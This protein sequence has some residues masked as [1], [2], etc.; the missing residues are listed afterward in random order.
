MV[1]L[2]PPHSNLLFSF[3]FCMNA[4]SFVQSCWLFS[5]FHPFIPTFC[6]C[7]FFLFFRFL[8]LVYCNTFGISTSLLSQPLMPVISAFK[9]VISGRTGS[10]APQ[11]WI[12]IALQL[13]CCWSGGRL[14]Q[15][16]LCHLPPV[17]YLG[18]LQEPST[19]NSI[20]PHESVLRRNAT[21][22]HIA[23]HWIHLFMNG[24]SVIAVQF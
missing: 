7:H 24:M 15:W 23:E 12:C 14:G 9:A 10:P 2:L 20:N 3:H 1:S 16:P 13:L 22:F 5:S 4:I 8:P 19:N 17:W 18:A 6:V 11:S 21:H